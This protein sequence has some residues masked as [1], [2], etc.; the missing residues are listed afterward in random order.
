MSADIRTIDRKF[1]FV[2]GKGGVGKSTVSVALARALARRGKRVLLAVTEP[3]PVS[4]LLGGI[5]V[6]PDVTTVEGRLSVLWVE[7]E[8]SLRDYGEVTLKSKTAYRALFDNKYAKTFLA[9]FPGLYQWASLGKAWFH[10][11][12]NRELGGST[13][14]VVVFDAPATGHGLEML[15]VPRVINDASPPGILRRDAQAAWDMLQDARRTGVLVV[16]L[17]EELPVQEAIELADEVKQMG[18]PLGGVLMNAVPATLFSAADGQ[19]LSVVQRV[20]PASAQE[21]QAIA[22]E[23]AEAERQAQTLHERLTRTF[24]APVL[25]LPWVASPSEASN[26]QRLI[27]ALS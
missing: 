26:M 4:G 12:G 18:V 19:K 10:A 20:L 7:P 23:H 14:D 24:D 13:F 17:P 22:R 5:P 27:D 1:L 16:T 8:Q 21:W 2:T 11:D 6:T 9:A 25:R 15:Q 3:G